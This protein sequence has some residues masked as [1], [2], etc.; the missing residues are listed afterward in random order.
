[1]SPRHLSDTA[2]TPHSPPLNL[3]VPC[4]PIPFGSS[5]SDE[6]R[7]NRC[8]RMS[9]EEIRKPTILRAF[10]S[11][12]RTCRVW[13]SREHPF[14]DCC[15]YDWSRRKSCAGGELRRGGPRPISLGEN[16]AEHFKTDPEVTQ[17]SNRAWRLVSCAEKLLCW[18]I[19]EALADCRSSAPR[20]R[21]GGGYG[22]TLA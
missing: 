19:R 14:F 18:R 16:I 8:L 17:T 20:L 11:P 6:H 12:K 15:Y 10:T 2:A 4:F 13:P 21:S 1:M 22:R 7:I 5:S 3:P 9:M